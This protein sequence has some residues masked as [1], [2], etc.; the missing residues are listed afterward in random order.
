MISLSFVGAGKFGRCFKVQDNN[1]SF[2]ILKIVKTIHSKEDESIRINALATNEYDTLVSEHG[3]LHV[4]PVKFDSF[5]RFVE[6]GIQLGVSYLMCNEGISLSKNITKNL[7]IQLL[8]S[9]QTI[10]HRGKY[11]GD[12]RIQNALIFSGEIMW[13]DFMCFG[14]T[15]EK[16]LMKRR[17]FEI[18]IN[19]IRGNK[20]AQNNSKL[21]DSL[22]AYKDDLTNTYDIIKYMF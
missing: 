4:V 22:N 12:P 10:H 21:V 7:F 3:Q 6:N 17:D 13:I 16:N 9:L 20:F 14:H 11:H 18:L 15:D 1:G 5:F 8:L 2:F 19:S